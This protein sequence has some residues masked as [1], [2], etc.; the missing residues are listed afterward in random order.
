MPTP[1]SSTSSTV[2]PPSSG[3]VRAL[4]HAAVRLAEVLPERDQP[5]H[6]PVVQRLR[7]AG[8]EREKAHEDGHAGLLDGG[9]RQAGVTSAKR[10]RPRP[11]SACTRWLGPW[12]AISPSCIAWPSEIRPMCHFASH[13]LS[14]ST[15]RSSS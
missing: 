10:L 8:D 6:R 5:L 4:G 1:S 15:T 13:S 9:H 14:V 2:W 11:E 3:R 12:T 7:E